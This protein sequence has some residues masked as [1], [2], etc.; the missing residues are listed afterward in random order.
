[1]KII[2]SRTDNLG[3]VVLTLPL[4]GFL[5]EQYP[6]SQL[7]FIGKA[8]TKAL[9]KASKHI[10]FFLDRDFILKNPDELKLIAADAI[11]FVF[12]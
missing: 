9:I 6:D 12:P 2:I 7:F 10:D 3:D 11:I 5:K 8:Y 1:M 4:A